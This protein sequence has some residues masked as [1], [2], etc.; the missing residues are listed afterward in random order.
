MTAEEEEEDANDIEPIP[1][2]F[3]VSPLFYRKIFFLFFFFFFSDDD[4]DDD[5][6]QPFSR[7][8]F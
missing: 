2:P 8:F 1:L 6:K 7:F 4:D 5:D 3:M